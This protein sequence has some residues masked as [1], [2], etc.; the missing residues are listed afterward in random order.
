MNNNI[1]VIILA[2][3]V[4]YGTP[5]FFAA[6]DRACAKFPEECVTTPLLRSSFD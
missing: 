1:L 6:S 3:G 5:I 2:S 4:F